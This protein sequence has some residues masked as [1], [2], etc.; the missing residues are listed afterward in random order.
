MGKL[1]DTDPVELR[2]ALADVES[3]KATKRLMIALA[4]MDGTPVTVLSER[5]DIPGSTIYYWLDR[6]EDRSVEDA[7][8]DEKRPGR[9]SKLADDERAAFEA[10]LQ[11]PPSAAGYDADEWTPEL[12]QRHLDEAFD[13]SYS[14]GHIQ[15]YFGYLL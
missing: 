13:V 2:E 12:A 10:A 4:Y 7:I 8:E 5:Y 14:V 9:P 3:A 15:N 6:F 1:E 11:Q